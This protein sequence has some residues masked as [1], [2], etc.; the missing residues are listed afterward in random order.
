LKIGEISKN[1]CK[2]LVNRILVSVF[3]KKCQR[4]YRFHWKATGLADFK[5]LV[6]LSAVCKRRTRSS[7]LLHEL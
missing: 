4:F 2:I 6:A 7:C 5:A 3:S 1:A